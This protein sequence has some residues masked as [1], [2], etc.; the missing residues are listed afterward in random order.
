MIGGARSSRCGRCM[1]FRPTSRRWT[2]PPPFPAM[3]GRAHRPGP[4]AT[5]PAF[6][7]RRPAS[8][9]AGAQPGR[10]SRTPFPGSAP[11]SSAL[12]GATG[13]NR[14]ATAERRTS[15]SRGR[16]RFGSIGH[17]HE[18]DAGLVGFGVAGDRPL[19]AADDLSGPLPP[20]R[21]DDR[22]HMRPDGSSIGASIGS[23]GRRFSF[24]CTADVS[25]R[26]RTADWRNGK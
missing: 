13:P 19:S 5:A 26:Y 11:P 3:P 14:R 10:A 7:S 2:A 20:F 16:R 21:R 17:S 4:N 24:R 9:S 18:I 6:R 25:A 15:A 1:V 23:P 22:C 8:R 12:S